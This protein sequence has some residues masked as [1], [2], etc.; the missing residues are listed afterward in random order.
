MGI[1][2]HSKSWRNSGFLIIFA[3]SGGIVPPAFK[4]LIFLH[5]LPDDILS[6]MVDGL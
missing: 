5:F 4:H 3:C 2:L 1:I 6:V